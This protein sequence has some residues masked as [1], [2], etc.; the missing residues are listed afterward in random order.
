MDLEFIVI[1]NGFW[2]AKAFSGVVVDENN[3]E[4]DWY[5]PFSQF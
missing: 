1:L 5:D 2:Q 4:V 3:A